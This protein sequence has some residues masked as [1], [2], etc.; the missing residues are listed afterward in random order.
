MMILSNLLG[1]LQK[2]WVEF[3]KFLKEISSMNGVPLMESK[4]LYIIT[5]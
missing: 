3:S 5:G 2:L 1:K 4:S